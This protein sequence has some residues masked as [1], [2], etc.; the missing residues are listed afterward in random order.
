MEKFTGKEHDE[1]IGLDYFGAWYYDAAI[2]RWLSRD[3]LANKYPSLSSYNYVANNPVNAFDPDGQDIWFVHGTFSNSGTWSTY[4]DAISAWEN[5]LSDR[6]YGRNNTNTL[7]SAGNFRWSGEN[8]IGARGAAARRLASQIAEAREQNPEMLVQL[9]GHSHGGNVSIET[10]N[11]LKQE[12]GITVDR[13]VLLGTPNRSDYQLADG[14]VTDLVNVYSNRDEV[15]THGGNISS[16]GMSSRFRK[17]ATNIKAGTVL[18]NNGDGSFSIKHIS[19]QGPISSHVT[20]HNTQ[21][22][23]DYINRIF[24]EN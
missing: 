12:Y 8:N 9:V 7:A 20:I 19:N 21:E 5:V 15:Q 6:V 24:N 4:M 11:I 2:S 1:A 17:G 14:A 10:A 23:I 13:L 3:P 18:V 16:L 22:L